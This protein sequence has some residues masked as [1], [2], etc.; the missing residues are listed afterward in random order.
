M[1]NNNSANQ[2]YQN[3]AD[4]AQLGGGVVKRVLKWLGAD[5]TLTGSGSNT[6]TMP[7]STDTLVGRASTDTLTNKTLASPIM[8]G[9]PTAPTASANDNSTKVATTAYVDETNIYSSS[10]VNTGKVW[11]DSRPIYRKVLRGQ[12]TIATGAN[13]IAHGIVSMTSSL[14]IIS[15]NGGIKLGQTSVAGGQEQLLGY[16]ETGGNWIHPISVDTTNVII[17][18]SFAWGNSYYSIIL[19]YVK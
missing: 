7:A 13:N 2:D 4:G 15:I 18:S 8:T 6:Y 16:R 3:N 10:E 1:A 12:F 5:I 17:T 11:V 9:T 14:E 19:E